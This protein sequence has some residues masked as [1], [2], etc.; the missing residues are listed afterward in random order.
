MTFSVSVDGGRFEWCGRDDKPITGLFAQPSN[1]VSPGYLKMLTEI[2]RFQKTVKAD[3]AASTIGDISLGAYLQRHRFGRR[4]RDD[5]VVPMGAAI[6]SMSPTRMLEYPARTF[7]EFFDNHCLLQWKRPQWRTVVGGS[8][9]YVQRISALYGSRL[10]LSTGVR[11]IARTGLGVD[12]TDVQGRREH[13]DHVVIAAHAP[14]ALAMLEQP[15]HHEQALLGAIS[16]APNDVVLHRDARLMPRRKAAWASWNFLR[17]GS[18]PAAPVA[19]TYWMNALQGIAENLPLF[20]SLN[21]PFEPQADKVFARFNYAHPQFDAGAL[22]ARDR[23]DLI[24]GRDHIW[25]CG[26]W[27]GHGFHEDGFASGLSVGEQLGGTAPW[28]EP[29][30]A[31]KL[32][33]E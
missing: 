33:A 28:L 1:L 18:D 3:L 17:A 20:V 11:S 22:A 7:A 16:Y 27:A 5:Y 30:G 26:A 14:D 13:F 9:A 8:R 4:V 19:V 6:W 29:S 24:Q 2:L 31:T 21:P 10:R 12:V 32:A 25:Y 15:S 23:L